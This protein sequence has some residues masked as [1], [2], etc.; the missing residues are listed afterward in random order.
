M[1]NM[2]RGFTRAELAVVIFIITFSL[3]ICAALGP[4][5]DMAQESANRI[6]CADRLRQ[7][8]MAMAVYAASNDDLLPWYG[9]VD[10]DFKPPF[11]CEMEYPYNP[12]D[13]C[14]RDNEIHPYVAFRDAPQTFI[15][16]NGHLIPLRLGCLYKAGVVSDPRIFYCPSETRPLYQYDSYTRPL[17]PNTSYEWGTLPQM[18]N[19]SQHYYGN[20]WVRTGYCYYPTSPS[21][22]IDLYYQAPAYTARRYSELDTAIP[23]LSDFIWKRDQVGLPIEELRKYPK[24]IAHQRGGIYAVNALFKDGSVYYCKDQRVF[25][26]NPTWEPFE[27]GQIT[28]SRFFYETYKAIARCSRGEE[29]WD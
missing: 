20:Q 27:M 12:H 10:P 13:D 6:I 21:I 9:G 28:Y 29:P 3:S 16:P 19:I 5:M 2:K 25:N 15:D 18:I 4:S 11:D 8:G 1:K 17:M 24:P 7:I 22:P 14:P 23:Y 26:D